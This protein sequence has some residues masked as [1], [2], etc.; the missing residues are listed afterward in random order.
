MSVFATSTTAQHAQERTLNLHPVRAVV[1]RANKSVYLQYGVYLQP[2]RELFYS[3]FGIDFW[4]FRGSI[5]RLG[6]FS[7]DIFD[8]PF[9]NND[10]HDFLS[11]K[12]P[13]VI[14]SR[15]VVLQH[16]AKVKKKILI[17]PKKGN[18]LAAKDAKLH[19]VY[20]VL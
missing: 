3:T 16:V 20:F 4:K 10:L 17:F 19:E 7:T 15:P 18:Y 8:N 12:D 2:L 14:L 6:Y 5:P 13:M 1:D 9:F 11:K